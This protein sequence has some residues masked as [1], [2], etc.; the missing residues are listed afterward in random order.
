MDFSGSK[1]MQMVKAKGLQKPYM[2]FPDPGGIV[3]Y[4]SRQSK[5]TCFDSTFKNCLDM[6]EEHE[7]IALND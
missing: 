2:F 4:Y 5:S 6:T 3:S 7:L 1:N